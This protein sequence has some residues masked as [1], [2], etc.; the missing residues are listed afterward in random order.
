MSKPASIHSW[1]LPED[2]QTWVRE[3]RGRDEYQRRLASWLTYLGPFPAHHVA[4]LLGVSKQSVWRWVS[5]YNQRGPQGRE[6]QGRGGGAG[7]TWPGRRRSLAWPVSRSVP[8][9]DGF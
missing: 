5:Q 4:R 1:L 7:R 8:S 6:R 9:R 2:L 3:A